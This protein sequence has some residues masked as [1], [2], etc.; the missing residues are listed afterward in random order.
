MQS[1]QNDLLHLCDVGMGAKL[2]QCMMGERSYDDV[3]LK[4]TS[5]VVLLSYI[6]ILFV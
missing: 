3:V 1:V 4:M 5:C 2:S 6:H